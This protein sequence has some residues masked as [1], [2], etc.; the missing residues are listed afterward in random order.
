MRVVRKKKRFH[1]RKNDNDDYRYK[2]MSSDLVGNGESELKRRLSPAFL[3]GTA[4]ATL[5]TL[6]SLLRF[7]LPADNRSAKGSVWE[8]QRVHDNQRINEF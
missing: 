4:A 2:K 3:N 8:R 5:W 1:A 7:F 6:H